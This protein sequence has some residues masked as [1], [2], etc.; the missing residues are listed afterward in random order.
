MSAVRGTALPGQASSRLTDIPGNPGSQLP[1]Q[2]GIFSLLF[3]PYLTG[4]SHFPDP[5]GLELELELE[6]PN[7]STMRHSLIMRYQ[8]LLIFSQ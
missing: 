2:P 7:N 1:C 6:F 3:G 8:K 4:L 5:G